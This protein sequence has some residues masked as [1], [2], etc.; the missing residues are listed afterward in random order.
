VKRA[1]V[2]VVLLVVAAA[3]G[4]GAR[5]TAATGTPSFG[6]RPPVGPAVL[7]P[8]TSVAVSWFCPVI[9]STAD[10]AGGIAVLNPT[11]TEA[12]VRVHVVPAKGEGSI[13]TVTLPARSTTTT[14]I[15]APPA[16]NDVLGFAAATI[17]VTERQLVVEAISWTPQGRTSAPCT[18]VTS[19]QWFAAEGATTKDAS[20]AL[21]L[22]N[23]FPGDAVVDLEFVSEEGR[24]EQQGVTVA[25]HALRIFDVGDRGSRRK[26]SVA[27]AARVTVG[28]LVV[29]RSLRFDGTSDRTGMIVGVISPTLDQTTWFADGTKGTGIGERVDLWNP[30][31]ATTEVSVTVFGDG[32]ATTL[33][34][35]TVT[36]APHTRKDVN[37]SANGALGSGPHRIELQSVNGVGYVGEL[38]IDSSAKAGAAGVSAIFGNPSG[39]YQWWLADGAT[40][41]GKA[42]ALVVANVSGAPVHVSPT[43]I[44]I[45]GQVPLGQPGGFD[46]GVGQ[47]ITVDLTAAQPSRTSLPVVVDAN[48]PVVVERVRSVG[49]AGLDRSLAV[50]DLS[51]GR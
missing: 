41:A 22:Y 38:V 42:M 31:E 32:D 21:A 48:G 33:D 51:V 47:A 8:P 43:E 39:A 23:P 16:T 5:R 28:R 9:T 13:T 20:Y 35:I 10:H 7:P 14:A 11:D 46:I 36:V 27:V 34:P 4:V 44:T 25:G 15:A 17:D 50:A 6:A 37:L 1:I 26:T 18:T 29:G 2:F 12:S 24:T 19:N 30:G 49:G 3:L 45:G 40:D